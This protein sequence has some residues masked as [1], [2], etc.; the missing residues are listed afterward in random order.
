MGGEKTGSW[1]PFLN[2]QTGQPIDYDK[3][4]GGGLLETKGLN[5]SIDTNTLATMPTYNEKSGNFGKLFRGIGS[6]FG[7]EEGQF[8]MNDLMG[9][10][11]IIGSAIG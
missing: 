5:T 10:A 4:Q 6:K 11:P 3:K 9:I 1:R 7:N 8:G 2:S